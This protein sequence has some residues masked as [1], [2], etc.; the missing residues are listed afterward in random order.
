M[1]SSAYPDSKMKLLS[2]NLSCTLVICLVVVACRGTLK[3]YPPVPMKT[4]TLQTLVGTNVVISSGI[5]SSSDPGIQT[6]II[7]LKM[8]TG[9]FLA[10]VTRSTYP[11]AEKAQS[12][13]ERAADR[14][15]GKLVKRKSKQ[16]LEYISNPMETSYTYRHDNVLVQVSFRD[17]LPQAFSAPSAKQQ[18]IDAIL[19]ASRE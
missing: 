13:L 9:A 15:S 19:A 12:E 6:Q 2:K 18:L 5:I 17:N 16:K 7:E 8:P 14:S 1:P 11:T 10:N 3:L 4:N